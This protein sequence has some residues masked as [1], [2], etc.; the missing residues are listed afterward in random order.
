L[1]F[2]V[3][4][5]FGTSGRLAAAAEE[6]RD[7]GAPADQTPLDGILVSDAPG[8]TVIS[9]SVGGVGKAETSI[10]PDDCH[11]AVCGNDCCQCGP[12]GRFWMQA[13]ALLWWTKGSRL[14]PLVTTSPPGT[15]REDAGVLPG[16]TILFGDSTVNGGGRAG[17]DTTLGMWLDCGHIWG[18]EAN[19][20]APGSQTTSYDSGLSNGYPIL[21]RPYVNV[22]D[23]S[24]PFN[25]SEL[26]AYP[27]LL[28]GRVTAQASDDFHSVGVDLRYNLLCCADCC[29]TGGGCGLGAC[30]NCCCGRTFRL[31]MIAGYR[32]YDLSDDLTIQE[33]LVSLV[34]QVQTGTQFNV[35]DSFRTRN[36]FNGAE[37]GLI[38]NYYC[39]PWSWQFSAQ[40][41]LGPNTEVVHIN[42]A[43][44]IISPDGSVLAYPGGLLALQTN[45]GDYSR[46]Q[47]VVIPQLGLE[48]GYQ[49]SKCLRGFVGYDFLYWG[50]VVRAGDQINLNIDTRNLPPPIQGAGP[51]PS[52]A[53]NSTSFWAQGIRLGAELR[54]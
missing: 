53:F 8:Q 6:P 24:E 39:G 31:D 28:G 14:P 11:S 7:Q 13:D 33:N 45:I 52:F 44:D 48:V 21:A 32:N 23:P 2:L 34:S 37:L 18:I 40:L 26:I 12:A 36:Y 43:T 5:A 51:Q 46:N 54:F 38:G 50:Q 42:G 30:S 4:L 16:A 9:D 15:P 10:A 35:V 47:F 25:D 17:V 19:Y 1:L 20:F 29:N 3:F 41:A 22:T 27:G 49:F